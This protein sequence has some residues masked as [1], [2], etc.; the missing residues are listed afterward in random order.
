MP[1]AASDFVGN[2]VMSRGDR[3]PAATGVHCRGEGTS[4]EFSELRAG[5][6]YEEKTGSQTQVRTMPSVR[7][8]LHVD[9]LLRRRGRRRGAR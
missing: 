1:P 7:Q 6:I 3:I 2:Y 4:N 9:D 5:W 8:M